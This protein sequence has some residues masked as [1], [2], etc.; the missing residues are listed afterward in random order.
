MDAT[1]TGSERSSYGQVFANRQFRLLFTVSTLAVAAD[2]L[3]IVTLSV[4]IYA[5]TGSSFLSAV[6][7]G[8]VFLPQVIGSTFFG[9]LADRLPPRRLILTGFALES[10][11][12][13]FLGLTHLPALVMLGLVA[14]NTAVIGAFAGGKIRILARELQGDAFVL[15][16]SV[17]NLA[18]SG[19]Q[20]IGLAA[21]GA[22]V[23]VLGPRHALLV[24]AGAHIVSTAI[25]WMLKKDPQEDHIR[26]ASASLVKDS[27]AGNRALLRMPEVRRNML[28]QWLP[29]TF[30][31]GAEGLIVAFAIHSGYGPKAP[32]LLLAGIPI[33]MIVGDVVVGRFMQ[34]ALRER[35][36]PHLVALMGLPLV[37]FAFHPNLVV[38]MVAV[39]ASGFGCASTLGMQRRFVDAVPPAYRGQAFSLLGTGMMTVQGLGAMLGGVASELMGIGNTM[40]LAGVITGGGVAWWLRTALPRGETMPTSSTELVGGVA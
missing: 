25:A 34:P 10:V 11:T 13:L 7:F 28:G 26:D 6:A 23:T 31:A 21:A 32:G 38:A 39:F 18:S 9:A 16:R 19:A 35:L 27:L 20:L 8:V 4:L 33:G 3:R 1:V 17:L 22:A 12:G 30:I 40:A 24:S 37:I 5:L 14:M 2:S 29:P 15:G 36:V